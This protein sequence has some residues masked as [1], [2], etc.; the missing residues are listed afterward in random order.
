M[1]DYTA[2]TLSLMASHSGL[3]D[4]GATPSGKTW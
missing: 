4:L 2:A 3:A 1:M